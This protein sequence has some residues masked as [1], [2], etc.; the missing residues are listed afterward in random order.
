VSMVGSV[1]KKTSP[2]CELG[3]EETCPLV[4]PK[5]WL[6]DSVAVTLVWLSTA[7]ADGEFRSLR[8]VLPVTCRL[9]LA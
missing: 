4:R 5:N 3:P 9:E 2:D 8:I 1:C 7:S 6:L